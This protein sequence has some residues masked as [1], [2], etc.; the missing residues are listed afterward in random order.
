MKRMWILLVIV[1]L[2]AFSVTPVFA[3][4][5]S[6]GT[7]SGDSNGQEREGGNTQSGGQ[8]QGENEAEREMEQE[9]E[10]EAERAGDGQ[11]DGS[12]E[13]SR[14]TEREREREAERAGD[15]QGDGSQEQSREKAQEREQEA[16]CQCEGDQARER[17]RAQ[18]QD[19]IANQ[20]RTR[21]QAAPGTAFDVMGTIVSVEPATGMLTIR[22]SAGSKAES[23]PQLVRVRATERT[24]LQRRSGLIWM[25]TR[26]GDLQPGQTIVARGTIGENAWIASRIRVGK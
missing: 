6:G 8:L 22:V 11:G 2:V 1:A 3:D 16:G 9:R 18:E 19:G 24:L 5:G 4:R 15:G 7:G 17:E 14:D 23:A 12:Q 13:Q 21:V 26:M 10:R 25:W 20:I